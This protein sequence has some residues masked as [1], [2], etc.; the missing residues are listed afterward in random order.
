MRG[1]SSL[2][3]LQNA[4]ARIWIE[5]FASILAHLGELFSA[6]KRLGTRFA[7]FR[8]KRKSRARCPDPSGTAV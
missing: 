2:I 7:R 3:A 4:D 5:A 6:E 8:N 1:D